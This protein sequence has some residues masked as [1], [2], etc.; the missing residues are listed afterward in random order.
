MGLSSED[1]WPKLVPCLKDFWWKSNP[2][3]QH[4]LICIKLW[5]PTHNL[6]EFSLVL[7]LPVDL[8]VAERS[9]ALYI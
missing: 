8:P 2:L 5:V 3:G 9:K 6:P 7:D 4:I 1:F